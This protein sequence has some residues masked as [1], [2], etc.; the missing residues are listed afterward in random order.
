MVPVIFDTSKTFFYEIITIQSKKNYYGNQKKTPSSLLLKV[1]LHMQKIHKHYMRHIPQQ[2]VKQDYLY[3]S[4]Y[5]PEYL[6]VFG[7]I[8]YK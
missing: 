2:H 5:L 3:S 6:T 8:K 1:L 7:K 4:E